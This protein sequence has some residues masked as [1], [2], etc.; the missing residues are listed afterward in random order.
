MVAISL[1]S[2]FRA[3]LDNDRNASV[4]LLNA[5]HLFEPWFKASGLPFFPGYTD[6]TMHSVV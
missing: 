4:F 5:T 6:L 3:K 2:R 1:P